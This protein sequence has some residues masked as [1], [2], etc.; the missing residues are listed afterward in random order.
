MIISS[1]PL[2][3]SL[4]G[5]STDHPLFLKKYKRGSVISFPSNLRV[6]V[7]LHKDVGGINGVDKKFIIN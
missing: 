3:I 2:R 6:Y 1:C 7:T 4:V 5:G